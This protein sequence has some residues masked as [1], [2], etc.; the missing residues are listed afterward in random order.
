MAGFLWVVKL[1]LVQLSAIIL[2]GRMLRIMIPR[3]IFLIKYIKLFLIVILL[4]LLL[5]AVF[6]M[7]LLGLHLF[8]IE[9]LYYYYMGVKLGR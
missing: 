6:V 7:F 9:L 3:I 2:C 4:V 1:I 8:I 5:Y